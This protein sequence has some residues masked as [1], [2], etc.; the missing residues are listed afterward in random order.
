L[1]SVSAKSFAA[2]TKSAYHYTK[3]KVS[4]NK[5]EGEAIDSDGKVIDRFTIAK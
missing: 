1:R 4:Q 5:V 2:F 3:L